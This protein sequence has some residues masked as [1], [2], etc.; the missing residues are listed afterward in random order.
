MLD[1]ED[2][3]APDD[4]EQAR[5][6]IIDALSELDWSRP[7]VSVRING[8]DTHYCYRDIVDVVER[9]GDRI[10]AI[11]IP[12]ARRRR[13][14]PR[15]HPALADRGRDRARAH[16]R[17][18]GA[19]RDG[20]RAWSTCDEIARACPERMEAMI[21]GVADY[22]AS[23]Q[24]RTT[25]IGGVDAVLGAHRRRPGRERELP[26]GRPVALPAGADRGD[27]P[28]PRAAPDRRAVRRLHRSRGLSRRRPAARPRSATR[29]NGR[30]TR[31]RS[32][33]RTRS[34]RP[35]TRSSRRPGGSSRR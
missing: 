8:L 19:D 33:S 9:A 31:R 3:V 34:S 25:S 24:A 26:L 7:S 4:K 21:F 10:D 17:A 1:L 22:A 29:A 30:S 11:V 16:D 32:S 18:D 2:A 27:L 14:P 5:V 12:K 13:R 35:T 28:R 6:N 15:R 20:D 23:I